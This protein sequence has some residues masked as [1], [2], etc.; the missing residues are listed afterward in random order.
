MHFQFTHFI[1]IYETIKN[2]YYGEKKII[3]RKK[4]QLNTW[5][6]YFTHH[7]TEQQFNW[8]EHRCLCYYEETNGP[9]W[10][11]KNNLNGTI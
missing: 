6:N 9:N 4:K 2:P 5:K 11:C 1:S 3:P 10:I 8:A 7:W